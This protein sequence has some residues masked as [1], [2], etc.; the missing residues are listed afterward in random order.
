MIPKKEPIPIQ[1]NISGFYFEFDGDETD[2]HK[3]AETFLNRHFKKI[4]PLEKD[5]NKVIS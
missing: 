5:P 2:A 1:T 3:E 4:F